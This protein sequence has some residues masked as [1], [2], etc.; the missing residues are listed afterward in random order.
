M[1]GD[2][3]GGLVGVLAGLGVVAGALAL[4]IGTPTSPQPGF[5]PF[6]GGAAV[7]L[8]SA[9]LLVQV[10]LGRS[11]GGEAFGEVRRPVILILGL[12]VY[13]AI[14]DPVG[15]VPAT[16]LI[17]GLI[18]RTL[19][20]TSWRVLGAASVSLSVGTYVL[21]ARLLGIELPA[22]VLAFLG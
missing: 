21:F 20:V 14:L 8:L 7:V 18:L 10:G 3:I 5:F 9:T 22:G 6:L 1:K 15:Y 19:G 17:T 12:A 11:S 2:V 13:V 4:R 16:A